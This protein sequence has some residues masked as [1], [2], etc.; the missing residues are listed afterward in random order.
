MRFLM[1]T[2]PLEMPDAAIPS[3][4][5]FSVAHGLCRL[6]AHNCRPLGCRLQVGN[7]WT[8]SLHY[9]P[10]LSCELSHNDVAV[11]RTHCAR[12]RRGSTEALS[13]R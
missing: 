6:D 3:G 8:C 1:L 12:R 9:V 7:A 5:E 11:A 2:M 4:G 13:Q 10:P